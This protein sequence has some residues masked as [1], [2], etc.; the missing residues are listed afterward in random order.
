MP[1][2][3]ASQYGVLQA[4]YGTKASWAVWGGEVCNIYPIIQMAPPTS[5]VLHNDYVLVGLNISR[6]I[7]PLSL[8]QNFHDCRKGTN[9]RKLAAEIHSCHFFHGAYMTDLLDGVV[10]KKQNVIKADILSGRIN[11]QPH[12][13]KFIQEMI[14]LGAIN[15]NSPKASTKFVVFGDVAQWIFN[16][17]LTQTAP[18]LGLSIPLLR[19]VTTLSPNVPNFLKYIPIP[20]YATRNSKQQLAFE[21]EIRKY[22]KVTKEKCKAQAKFNPC[23]DVL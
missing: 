12:L 4:K 11:L 9:D 6:C 20:H 15:Q 22:T 13:I 5:K 21:T 10:A 7:H 14:D 2:I 18:V 3:T 23:T 16:V 1:S 17:F 8:W 19:L